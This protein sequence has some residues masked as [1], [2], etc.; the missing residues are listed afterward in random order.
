MQDISITEARS[1]LGELVDIV[2]YQGEGVMLT[3]SG[4]PVA[5]L[6]PAHLFA[7]WIDRRERLAALVEKARANVAK[8]GMTEE[9]IV[10]LVERTIADV[11]FDQVESAL[12]T[13][14]SDSEAK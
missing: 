9:E 2:H 12:A 7:E 1:R 5:A 6:V 11:R 14:V 3:K 13:D 8:T 10:A 4:K